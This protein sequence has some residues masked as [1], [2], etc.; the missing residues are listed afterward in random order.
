ME[1]GAN[2]NAVSADGR[3]ALD[4]AKAQGYDSVVKFLAAVGQVDNQPR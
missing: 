3:A 2:M 4:A 1:L